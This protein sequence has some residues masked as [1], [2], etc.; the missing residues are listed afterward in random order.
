MQNG[1]FS[2][3]ARFSG[4][5][6]A[7]PLAHGAFWCH[8]APS[9][10]QKPVR[11]AIFIPCVSRAQAGALADEFALAGFN[12]TVKPGNQCSIWSGSSPFASVA[13]AWAC[14]VELAA[15]ETVALARNTLVG[16]RSYIKMAASMGAR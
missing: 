1:L 16:V 2:V 14:K 7:R 8:R 4:R 5:V 11:S 9:L 10:G 15:G 6:V 13:P 3:P 12:Y